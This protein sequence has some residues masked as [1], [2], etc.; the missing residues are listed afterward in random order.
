M[1]EKIV[2]SASRELLILVSEK[3]L[4]PRLGTKGRL[5]VEVVPFGL[6]FCL[7]RFA[8]LGFRAIPY[9]VHGELFISDNGNYIVDLEIEPIEDPGRFEQEIKRV[10][11]VIDTG[12]FLA[13]ADLVLVGKDDD[14]QLVEERKGPTHKRQ[15]RS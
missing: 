1:R 10:P 4:A 2:A 11:G 12:L 15:V 13:M 14:F 7:R 8:E 9:R 3:K 6:P 5:P